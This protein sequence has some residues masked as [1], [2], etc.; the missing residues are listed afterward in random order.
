MKAQA[1]RINDEWWLMKLPGDPGVDN[2]GLC[3]YE[4]KTIFIRAAGHGS[5]K[6]AELIAHEC[7]HAVS[8]D[9]SEDVVERIGVAVAGALQ[10]AGLL[11]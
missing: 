3:D 4:Q 5:R 2:D 11:K 7:A 6:L 8:R 9:L 10:S 1:I